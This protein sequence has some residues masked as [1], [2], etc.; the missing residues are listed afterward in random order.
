MALTSRLHSEDPPGLGVARSQ[1]LALGCALHL[2]EIQ[3]SALF[4]QTLL[5]EPDPVKKW[6]QVG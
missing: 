2:L 3:K 1:D 6:K 5:E 4:V